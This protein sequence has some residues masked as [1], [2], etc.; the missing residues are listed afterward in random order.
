[1][2]NGKQNHIINLDN[3]KIFDYI[4]KLINNFNEKKN[5]IK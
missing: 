1:M 2:K 4:K 3:F 5:Y